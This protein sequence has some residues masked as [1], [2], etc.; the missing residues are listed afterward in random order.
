[1]LPFATLSLT[2]KAMS[3]HIVEAGHSFVDPDG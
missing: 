2:V 1:M 3:L